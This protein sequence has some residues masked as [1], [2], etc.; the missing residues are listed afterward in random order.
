MPAVEPTFGYARATDGA[1]LAYSTT[2]DGPLD[3][4]WQQDWFSNVDLIWE[5]PI[6]RRVFTGV[7][8]TARLILHDRRGTGLSSRNVPPP[9]LETR[10]T[11]LIAVLDEVEAARPVLAGEREG[12]APN[13][14]LAATQPDRVRSLIWYAPTPRSVWAPDYPWGARPE[15]IEGEIE[16]VKVWGTPAY[17]EAFIHTESLGDHELDPSMAAL[18][19]RASRHTATPDV[20]QQMSKIWYE[21]D[22]REVLPAVRVPTLIAQFERP[23]R[24][25]EEARYVSSLMPE[26]ELVV[27]PGTEADAEVDPF[28]DAIRTFLGQ[29][30]PAELDTI[31]STVLFT[32]IVDSTK[33]QASL[34]D[35]R[36]KDLVLEHHTVV[37]DALERW[38]GVENDT[39]GD[40]FYATFDGPARAIRCAQE[41]V[42]RVRPIGIEI[43]AGIH[44]G[45]CEV[46]DGKCGG[47]T[48][49]IGARIASHAGP[50]TVM[51]SQTVKDLVAGSGL[52]FTDAGAYELKGVPDAWRLYEVSG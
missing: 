43:R 7:S 52:H 51:V 20:A 34:G 22:V 30:R 41:V 27:L 2:G 10:V 21:S 15:Y 29:D 17:G 9:N 16:S 12:G 32:D 39:A 19:A 45:E 37:R 44:T 40:G 23:A 48:V 50:S 38:H 4:A 46:I 36:W 14:L 6:S 35:H 25:L 28:L 24:G 8:R 11:D 31:L 42:E 47:L 1:Y 33:T 49:S 18:I 3:I 13:A 26:A 5:D